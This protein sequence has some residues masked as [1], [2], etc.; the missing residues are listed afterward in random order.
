MITIY[1]WVCLAGIP[2]HWLFQ[3]GYTRHTIPGLLL[4]IGFPASG[5][6]Y[7]GIPSPIRYSDDS[8]LNLIPF[9]FLCMAVDRYIKHGI[10][11]R[12]HYTIRDLVLL[13]IFAIFKH[14]LCKR[15]SLI[16]A[17]YFSKEKKNYMVIISL[18]IH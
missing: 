11:T 12:V 3:E 14:L 17:L 4:Q 18:A 10:T 7:T 1:I 15:P 6:S 8:G 9:D 13:I 2:V 16:T 5:K